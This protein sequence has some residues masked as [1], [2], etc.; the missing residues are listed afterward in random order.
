MTSDSPIFPKAIEHL[1]TELNEVANQNSPP[2]GAKKL[3]I[4]I[5]NMIDVNAMLLNKLFMFAMQREFSVRFQIVPEVRFH[6]HARNRIVVT[7]LESDSDYLVMIDADVDPN[8]KLLEMV[9][10]DKDIASGNIFCWINGQV[11]PSIW[12][13][14]PCEQCFCVKKF[15]DAGLVHD[16]SQYRISVLDC[17]G[18]DGQPGLIDCLFRWNPFRQQ[19][20]SLTTRE[21]IIPGRKCRCLGTG[22][23]PF[24]YRVHPGVVGQGKLLQC[25]S[26]GA[27]SLVVARRVVE[28]MSRPWF[29]FL[30]KEMREIMLTEDHFFCWRAKLEGFEVWADPQM[31][32]SH[33]KTVDLFA[34]NSLLVRAWNI[35]REQLKAEMQGPEISSIILP[36][37]ILHE[38]PK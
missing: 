24:V 12:T 25:D 21:G 34:V 31:A 4:A 26:V 2:V 22:L 23:D 33:F 6:D 15:V 1:Q 16:P 3:F 32:G 20:E 27:A 30:Y 38:V 5:P 35:G 18:K 11:M 36:P 29:Q 10:L 8:P 9:R 19:Y 37:G 14:A 7:F 28:K 17:A 13:R